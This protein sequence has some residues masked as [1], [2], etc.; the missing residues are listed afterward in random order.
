[1][2]VMSAREVARGRAVRVVPIVKF[3]GVVDVPLPLIPG[4]S[5]EIE[6]R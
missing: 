4:M 6:L 2:I 3:N 1:M 5:H